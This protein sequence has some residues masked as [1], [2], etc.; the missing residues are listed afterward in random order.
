MLCLLGRSVAWSACVCMCLRCCS[1]ASKLVCGMLFSSREIALCVGTIPGC[2]CMCTLAKR[3]RR[4]DMQ[5]HAA[6]MSLRLGLGLGYW[7]L[8]VKLQ[9]VCQAHARA[10]HRGEGGGCRWLVY[11]FSNFS[12]HSADKH[13]VK[14]RRDKQGEAGELASWLHVQLQH[15]S[16]PPDLPDR[17]AAR[18]GQSDEWFS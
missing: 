1:R 7:W 10:C 2:L 14:S 6:P 16:I 9:T 17:P 4:G 18:R 8:A 15:P 12:L 11:P 5:P 3:R 13:R